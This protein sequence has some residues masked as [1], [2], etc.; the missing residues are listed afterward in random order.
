MQVAAQIAA[1]GVLARRVA[2]Q[3]LEVGGA[4]VVPQ[5]ALRIARRVVL[6]LGELVWVAAKD[7]FLLVGVRGGLAAVFGP[8]RVGALPPVAL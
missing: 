6:Q 2:C 1:K 4:L 7:V 8:V 5:L 3:W